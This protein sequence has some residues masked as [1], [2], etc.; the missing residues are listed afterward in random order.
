[1][2]DRETKID[3]GNSPD[4]DYTNWDAWEDAFGGV[5][6]SGDCAGE[7]ERAVGLLINTSGNDDTAARVNIAGWTSSDA[8]YYPY[9]YCAPLYRHIGTWP[10]S[11]DNIYRINAAGGGQCEISVPYTRVVGVAGRDRGGA[12]FRVRV[13]GAWVDKC[14]AYS[15]RLS[16]VAQGI[17]IDGV[18]GTVW[19]KITNNIVQG[20]GPDAQGIYLATNSVATFVAHNTVVN[21]KYHTWANSAGCQLFNNLEYDTS[22][23]YVSATS[24]SGSNNGY[25]NGSA[26][27]TDDID[28]SAVAGADIF[29]DYAGGDY[30]L[31]EGNGDSGSYVFGLGADL[32]AEYYPVPD[33]FEDHLRS[34][35]QSLGF[36]EP[37][38]YLD[39]GPTAYEQLQDKV[40]H[41]SLDAV[42]KLNTYH[43]TG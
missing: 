23:G 21:C 40:S 12:V 20:F 28:L 5:A 22:L 16:G 9:A 1:M 10:S 6:N 42:R 35:Y 2:A 25:E 24:F 18:S 19:P 17:S 41:W 36:D 30:R 11:G 27:T 26:P 29:R 32:S 39:P 4:T 14:L 34:T 37:Q 31:P 7:Q 13:Q 43:P 8:D 3:P 33:D 15:E 38:V